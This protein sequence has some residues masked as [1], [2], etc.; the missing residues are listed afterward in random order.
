MSAT[1]VIQDPMP[2]PGG[3]IVQALQGGNNEGGVPQD[4]NPI[5]GTAQGANHKADQPE[6]D[7]VGQT[8]VRL[9]N[10][11]CNDASG[12]AGVLPPVQ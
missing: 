7:G 12:G 4:S 5:A 1:R 6:P 11:L 8:A 9:S 10:G 2:A 3:E